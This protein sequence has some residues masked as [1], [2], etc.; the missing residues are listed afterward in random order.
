MANETA[1]PTQGNAPAANPA[2]PAS[3][4][5]ATP[6]GGKGKSKKKSQ[7]GVELPPSA[8]AA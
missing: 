3:A 7:M 1:T 5:P 6:Q 8:Q 2:V 4:S